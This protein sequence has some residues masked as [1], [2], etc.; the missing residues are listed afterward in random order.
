MNPKDAPQLRKHQRIGADARADVG[1]ALLEQYQAGSSI[2]N[3]AAATG[4][5]I[6]RVRGL[7]IEAGV[8]FRSQGGSNHRGKD[9]AKAG[10][11]T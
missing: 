11:G 4:Y 5:S 1:R 2:R 9:A 6:T 10:L 8:T 7:L 3:L